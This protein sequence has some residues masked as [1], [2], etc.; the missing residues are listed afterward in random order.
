MKWIQF[1]STVMEMKNKPGAAS[2]K[3]LKPPDGYFDRAHSFQQNCFPLRICHQPIYRVIVPDGN[4]LP[5]IRKDRSTKY[6]SE[7]LPTASEAIS[8]ASEALPFDA[9]A[10]LAKP[11]AS[12]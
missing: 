8:A 10:I 12:L 5:K 4:A 11:E 3:R 7:T 2:V 1:A 6:P 9:E